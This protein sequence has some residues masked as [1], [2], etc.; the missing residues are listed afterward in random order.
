MLKSYG[1]GW[2]E[3][4]VDIHCHI[5]PELDDGATEVSVSHQM[6]EMAARD[7]ITDLVATP[8]SNYQYTFNPAI[9]RAKRD[10]LQQAMGS[11]R[12]AHSTT[13]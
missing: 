10:A 6:F 12:A 3:R 13:P 4:M 11:I 8:H 2:P 5:L 7:G 1:H 9:N